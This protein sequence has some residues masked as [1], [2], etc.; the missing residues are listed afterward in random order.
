MSNTSKYDRCAFIFA[1]IALVSGII[2]I[3]CEFYPFE[4]TGE[5]GIDYLGKALVWVMMVKVLLYATLAVYIIFAIIATVLALKTIK[6]NGKRK[7]G[8]ISLILSWSCG[9]VIA[10]VVLTNIIVDRVNKRNIEVEVKE[11]DLTTDSDGQPAVRVEIELYNGSGR[12]ISY[13]SSV[14]DEVT[15]NGRELSHAVLSETMNDDDPDIKSVEP[16]D[17]I[18]IV[19]G[20][21]LEY[22]D[23]PVYIVC[24]SYDGNF[25]YVDGE[26]EAEE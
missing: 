2:H 22:P 26:F 6:T 7:K 11:V 14:Y 9:I 17:S 3:F 5:G 12:S 25:V 8:V 4:Y 21:E 24:R 16:G 23:E 13:L 18:T 20:Y 10:G 1:V 15:Q 19:K